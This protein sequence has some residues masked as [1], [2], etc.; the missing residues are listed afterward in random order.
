MGERGYHGN[1]SYSLEISFSSNAVNIEYYGDDD[2]YL[3]EYEIQYVIENAEKLM[4]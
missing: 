2:S 1:I 3:E 4:R